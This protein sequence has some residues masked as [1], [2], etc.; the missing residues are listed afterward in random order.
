ML[1][2]LLAICIAAS[3][4]S[5]KPVSLASRAISVG[6]ALELIRAK[7]GT[8]L[9][10]EAEIA[11]DPVILQV[12]NVPEDALLQRIAK[13]TLGR[14]RNEKGAWI[15]SRDSA[16]LEAARRHVTQLFAQ[17]LAKDI[18]DLKAK[19][20]G[21][22]RLTSDNM[23]EWLQ[24]RYSQMHITRS[25]DGSGIT[26]HDSGVGGMFGNNGTPI[27]RQTMADALE[28]IAPEEVAALDEHARLVLSTQPTRAQIDWGEKGRAILQN[29]LALRRAWNQAAQQMPPPESSIAVGRIGEV[30]KLRLV[31]VR[32]KE[33]LDF[34]LTALT[35]KG[36]IADQY[37]AGF[38]EGVEGNEEPKPLP[39]SKAD[40]QIIPFDSEAQELQAQRDERRGATL[41]S[42][43]LREKLMHPTKHDPLE[44]APSEAL[45]GMA[46]AEQLNLVASVPDYDLIPFEFPMGGSVSVSDVKKWLGRL[47]AQM[48]DGWLTVSSPDPYHSV[49]DRVARRDLEALLDDIGRSPGR[50]IETIAAFVNAHPDER[51]YFVSQMLDLTFPWS[52]WDLT[53]PSIE[54]Y[55]SLSVP[56]REVLRAGNPLPV[57]NLSEPQFALLERAIF[58]DRMGFMEGGMQM[59]IPN[60]ETNIYE[61]SELNDTEETEHGSRIP[62]NSAVTLHE[63]VQP[64]VFYFKRESGIPVSFSEDRTADIIGMLAA[65]E[66][67][68]KDNS[69]KLPSKMAYCTRRDLTFSVPNPAWKPPPPQLGGFMDSLHRPQ[70][71]LYFTLTE[72]EFPDYKMV[73]YDELPASFLD[74]VKK[75]KEEAKARMAGGG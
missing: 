44:W 74:A 18:A 50:R 71:Y 64:A 19:Y 40:T 37:S 66:F 12:N 11:N 30:A 14:W 57:S 56:E 22:K 41:I 4:Q 35:P 39:A 26:I 36:K 13:V 10:A 69:N 59:A 9:F 45:M 75:A 21:D 25:R 43:G 6:H 32:D 3:P 8:P 2:L 7:T 23:L 60:P 42:D 55:G 67:S 52:Q 17:F 63:T 31:I 61:L 53:S 16:Q 24:K 73:A 72:R 27:I 38:M 20:S 49:R 1:A 54:W 68:S 47:D 62:A 33:S 58:D 5:Q 28:S 70:R 15:L 51:S 29:Y 48:Q 46:T 65:S 34:T